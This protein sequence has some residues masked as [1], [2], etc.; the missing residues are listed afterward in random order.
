MKPGE[1]DDS[2]NLSQHMSGFKLVYTLLE[3]NEWVLFAVCLKEI[4]PTSSFL[5]GEFVCFCRK[6]R[7]GMRHHVM[8]VSI[9]FNFQR[10][11]EINQNGFRT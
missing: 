6:I 8:L 9:K 7:E 3:M 10:A 4:N 11:E 1:A 5:S 2:T